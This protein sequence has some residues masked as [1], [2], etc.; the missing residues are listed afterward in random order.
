MSIA[1]SG[2]GVQDYSVSESVS[3]YTK[4][5]VATGND[6]DACRAVHMKG[7]SASV[8]LTV[9]NTVVAFWLLKGHTYPICAT[10]SSSTDVVFLY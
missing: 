5:V 3:P 2:K 1:F 4:A 9:D 8:N 6:Q 7:A 10:K